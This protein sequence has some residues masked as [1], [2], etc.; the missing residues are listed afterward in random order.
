VGSTFAT[1]VGIGGLIVALTTGMIA[2]ALWPSVYS[3][4][5]SLLSSRIGGS[6]FSI[7]MA[8]FFGGV[9]YFLLARKSDPAEAE[10]AR[11]QVQPGS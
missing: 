11:V 9:S 2:A 7:F 1:V 5:V 6:D 3:P 8:L 4:Y 10:Q